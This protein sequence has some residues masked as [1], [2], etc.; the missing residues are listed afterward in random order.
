MTYTLST[1]HG[2]Q[3]VRTLYIYI[4]Y[5]TEV[6]EDCRL[7]HSNGTCANPDLVDGSGGCGCRL[8]VQP[9]PTCSNATCACG[10]FPP[11]TGANAPLA[12]LWSC[13]THCNLCWWC[14]SFQPLSM[15]CQWS[16]CT[17]E[18]VSAQASSTNS[19]SDTKV[20][21]GDLVLAPT[22]LPLHVYSISTP[23]AWHCSC[24]VLLDNQVDK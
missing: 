6:A 2:S 8:L 20:W 12:Q 11:S 23:N 15:A 18:M 10:D 22:N 4:N 3:S 5:I 7:S 1:S 13:T 9:T 14:L 24:H 16:T 19:S 21:A 17:H